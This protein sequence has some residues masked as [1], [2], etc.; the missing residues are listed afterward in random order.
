MFALPRPSHARRIFHHLAFGVAAIALVTPTYAQDAP[1]DDDNIEEIIVEGRLSRYSATKM[2]TPIFETARSVSI[3]DQQQLLD[4]GVLELA[5]AYVYAPGVI[6]QTY[7]FA[8][9]GD[10]VKVRGLDVPE[11]R[12]S[13]Q[14]LFGNYNN[15]RSHVYTLEQVEILKGPSSV[16]Y[17]QGSPGGLVNVV[18]KRPQQ[19]ASNEIVAEYGNFDRKQIAADL[20]GPLDDDG[21][22]LYRMTAVYRDADTQIDY[23]EDDALVIA[24]S[25][26][27]RPNERTNVTILG[28][29]QDYNGQ[30]AAQFVPTQGA[31]LP[32]PNGE[33]FDPNVFLGEPEFDRYDTKTKS[34]TLLADHDFNASWGMEA[35]ARYTKG[36][37]KYNQAWPAFIGGNR[38]LDDEG[39]VARTFYKNEADSKQFAVDVRMRGEFSTGRLE[40]NLLVGVDYQ[41]VTTNSDY[42]YAFAPAGYGINIFNPVYGNVP[43]DAELG[44]YYDNPENKNK[45]IGFSIQDQVRIG[46]LLLTLGLRG[47]KVD[48]DT[49]YVT[50]QDKELSTNVGVMYQL[51]GG[52]SP[53]ASY[54][55]SF[56]PVVGT[57]FDGSA[58][59]PQMGKQY[60]VG[61]KYQPEGT[62]ALITVSYF[63][64]DQTNLLTADPSHPGFSVQEGDVSIKG[65]EF[66]AVGNVG[67][68]YLEG[69]YSY[70]DT[71]TSD[72]F[73]LPSIPA[74]Q[75][76]S[77]IT[78]RPSEVMVGFKAGF[79]V[80]YVGASWDGADGLKTPS[81][82]LADAMVGYET[83]RFDISIN[84]HNL[85]NKQYWSTCI[86]RGDC[87]V[88][89][90][91][92]VVARLAVK[93]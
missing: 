46:Q 62:T 35:T 91:R 80:R 11:Y 66:E 73:R 51:P 50:Q 23:V 21:R 15:T 40:H 52:F 90:D 55:E 31:L 64:I 61:I 89:K 28:N 71:E 44:P 32:A 36:E 34:I 77:W 8:T 86:A 84:A 53:Y 25:I 74:H 2:D 78:W 45:Q 82:T 10:W 81:Y 19:E 30:A 56:E 48:S 75:A 6:G 7:G 16:L 13:L 68:F 29:Y 60:E 1:T 70:L 49:G 69:N 14:A 26:T 39:N 67:D 76:S 24:P 3:E 33:H 41:D 65:F 72:G 20:T 38:Y 85:T 47:D 5:D 37:A 93:F 17:G 88:G 59:A 12:D 18:S 58:Y 4:K 79:G 22:F 92:T 43:T 54:S 63:D 9:R 27:W 87:F 83:D 57:T 42:Y